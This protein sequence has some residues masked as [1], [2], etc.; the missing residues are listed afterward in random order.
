MIGK[1]NMRQ[2]F[3]IGDNVKI[4]SPTIPWHNREG[5]IFSVG[6]SYGWDFNYIVAIPPMIPEPNKTE[7]VPFYLE[8]LDKL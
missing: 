6:G 8:E 5:I 1:N 7:K 4:N 3:K 2:T